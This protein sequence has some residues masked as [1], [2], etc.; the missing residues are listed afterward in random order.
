M[1]AE[2][3]KTLPDIKDFELGPFAQQK[4]GNLRAQKIKK[5]LSE[6]APTI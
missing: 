1:V 6:H 4:R 3:L 2:A 5:K